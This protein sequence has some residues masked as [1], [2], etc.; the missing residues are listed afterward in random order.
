MHEHRK[1][2]LLRVPYHDEITDKEVNALSVTHLGEVVGDAFQDILELSFLPVS[3]RGVEGAV[4][5]LLDLDEAL[6]DCQC[7][8]IMAFGLRLFDYKRL[9]FIIEPQT[10]TIFLIVLVQPKHHQL[11]LQQDRIRNFL[12]RNQVGPTSEVIGVRTLVVI[13]EEGGVGG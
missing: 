5:V 11:P 10:L 7:A 1:A 2:L 3:H 6:M 13:A 9:V 4:D 8:L 12:S